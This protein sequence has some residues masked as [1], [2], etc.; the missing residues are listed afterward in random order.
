[1]Y[2]I[3]QKRIQNN[4]N[5]ERERLLNSR[6]KSFSV[7]L[8]R[9]PFATTFNVYDDTE[10]YDCI[11]KPKRQTHKENTN[12][13]LCENDLDIVKSGIIVTIDNDE[14]IVYYEEQRYEDAYS[15]WIV[16]KI[17]NDI[18]WHNNGD[19]NTYSL[20]GY[21]TNNRDNLLISSN[22]ETSKDETLYLESNEQ[23]T[24]AMPSHPELKNDSY[25]ELSVGE[26]SRPYRIVG[27]DFTAVPGIT[28]ATAVPTI[29]RQTTTETATSFWGGGN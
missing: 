10:K 9:S 11:F 17:N 1:M 21:V 29:E 13:L 25:F 27:Y 23:I 12:H 18:N 19:N 22:R 2:S 7:F 8:K 5:T 4:G 6:K 28:I 14:Y 24:I 15:K 20:K 3:Y 26:I 16:L